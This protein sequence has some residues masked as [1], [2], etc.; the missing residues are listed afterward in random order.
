MMS[1]FFSLDIFYLFIFQIL[2]FGCHSFWYCFSIRHLL[3][4][5]I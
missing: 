3:F 2:V 4:Q 1:D 5:I